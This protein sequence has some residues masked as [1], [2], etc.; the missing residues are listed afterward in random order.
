[1]SEAK[2][3]LSRAKHGMHLREI[4]HL[5]LEDP[6]YSPEELF[7]SISTALETN[8]NN[9]YI[10]IVTEHT[11]D[12]PVMFLIA[13]HPPESRHVFIHQA[14]ASAMLED[15]TVQDR[16]FLALILW[17]KGF[18]VSEIRMETSRC[19]EAFA[20]RWGFQPFSTVMHY[21]IDDNLLANLVDGNHSKLI[22]VNNGIEREQT[23]V[24]EQP[25]GTAAERIGRADELPPGTDRS[26]P[27]GVS[28]GAVSDDTVVQPGGAD[29]ERSGS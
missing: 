6:D 22:G 21:S 17:T 18:G 8:Y 7:D 15:T 25:L 9:T 20:R 12:E 16:V 26:G 23:D 1:M 5:L 14:W 4:E 19:P 28:G 11:Q 2:F 27:A 3:K 24:R 10:A 29:P 13:V